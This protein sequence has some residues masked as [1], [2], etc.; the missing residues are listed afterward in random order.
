M[1]IT[2]GTRTAGGLMTCAG[3][4]LVASRPLRVVTGRART[5]EVPMGQENPE[6][7]ARNLHFAA[8]AEYTNPR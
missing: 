8:A 3:V 6:T 4:L 2:P 7:K 1:V 5:G